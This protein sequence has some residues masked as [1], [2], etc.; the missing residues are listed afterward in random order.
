MLK[1]KQKQR[2]TL[3]ITKHKQIRVVKEKKK[4]ISR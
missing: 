2:E 4:F 3:K 1:G